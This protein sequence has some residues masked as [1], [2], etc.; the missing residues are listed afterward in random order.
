MK[1]RL[2]FKLLSKINCLNVRTK[3]VFLATMRA[4]RERNFSGCFIVAS[5]QQRD[6]NFLHDQ[7]NVTVER[8]QGKIVCVEGKI[9]L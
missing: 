8:S 2:Q 1:K 9:C 7:Q 4:L 6:H 3:R 5:N